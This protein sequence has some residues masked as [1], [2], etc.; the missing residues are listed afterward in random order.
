MILVFISV[1]L[2]DSVFYMLCPR[3]IYTDC[4]F[5]ASIEKKMK[6]LS[7]NVHGTAIQIFILNFVECITRK[8]GQVHI[9]LG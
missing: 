7:L 2:T 3:S 9:L 8:I 4:N 1:M 6:L 5:A